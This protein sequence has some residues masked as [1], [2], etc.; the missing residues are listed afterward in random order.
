MGLSYPID[1]DAWAAWQ[2]RQN[3]LRWAKTEARQLVNRLRGSASEESAPVNGLLYTR[4]DQP[5]VL[6]VLDSFSPTTVTL[7]WSRSSTCRTSMWL[8]GFPRKALLS[9]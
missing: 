6:I 8:C 7:C 4:G 3:T 9:T 2:K 1:I 5:Q